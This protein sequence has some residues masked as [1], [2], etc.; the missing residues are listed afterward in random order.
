MLKIHED[1]HLSAHPPTHTQT[2]KHTHTHNKKQ[3]VAS[4]LIWFQPHRYND[5]HVEPHMRC[6]IHATTEARA[7]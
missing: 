6:K 2:N 1:T 3:K 7:L 5:I 4:V